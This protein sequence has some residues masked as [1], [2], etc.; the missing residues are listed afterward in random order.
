MHELE[1]ALPHII[2]K[3]IQY[4]QEGKEQLAEIDMR[5]SS[6][7]KTRE[8]YEDSRQKLSAQISNEF[9]IVESVLQKRKEELLNELDFFFRPKMEEVDSIVADMTELR[10]KLKLVS[11][12]VPETA[13]R[14]VHIYRGFE[15]I[16]EC[17]RKLE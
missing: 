10:N 6:F 16:K 17:L 12:S 9:R 15:T 2:K 14:E 1:A 3:N 4:R 7:L 13:D 5:I 8:E 11:R